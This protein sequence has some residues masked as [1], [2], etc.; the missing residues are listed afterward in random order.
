[1]LCAD[2]EESFGQDCMIRRLKNEDE[3]LFEHIVDVVNGEVM[4]VGRVRPRCV[5][6]SQTGKKVQG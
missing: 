1:M 2:I 3:L 5:R 4:D 6:H